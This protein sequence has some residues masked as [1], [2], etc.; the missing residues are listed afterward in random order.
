[1]TVHRDDRG[2]YLF[3]PPQVMT[4]IM[5]LGGTDGF[6]R[7]VAERLLA[8]A[9]DAEDIARR[10]DHVAHTRGVLGSVGEWLVLPLCFTGIWLL[11]WGWA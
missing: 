5:A 7:A 3:G 2:G 1:M 10:I 6:A 4:A 8:Q 9:Y 11:A